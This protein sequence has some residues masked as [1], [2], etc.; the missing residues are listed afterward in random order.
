MQIQ[1]LK[2]IKNGIRNA[3]SIIPDTISAL[4]FDTFGSN[5]KLTSEQQTSKNKK[6]ARFLDF[7]LRFFLPVA[8][9]AGLFI[10]FLFLVKN[11][12]SLWVKIADSSFQSPGWFVGSP[13]KPDPMKKVLASIPANYP[14]DFTIPEIHGYKLLGSSD[15]LQY[16]NT[17]K[18]EKY[19]TLI[20]SSQKFTDERIVLHI[21]PHECSLACEIEETEL[22]LTRI[23]QVI[24]D[25]KVISMFHGV[26]FVYLLVNYSPQQ[27]K[28]QQIAELL[29]T[30][31]K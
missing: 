18:T 29:K 21:L 7:K 27:E 26:N 19:L 2:S 30:S 15:S 8:F 4:D 28:A 14:D 12:N 31:V 24:I 11:D 25:D 6:E 16:I 17:E 23:T 10:L 3:F 22:D 9:S 13:E 1:G 5:E 20:Y